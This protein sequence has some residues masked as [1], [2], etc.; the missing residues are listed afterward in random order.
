MLHDFTDEGVAHW[1]CPH[2]STGNQA[3]VSHEEMEAIGNVVAL[4]PCACGT[5]T[6]LKAQ[7]TPDE[8]QTENMIDKDGNTTQSHHAAHLHMRAAAQVAARRTD[9]G[10]M[11]ISHDIVQS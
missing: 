11:E 8:L 4:P 1:V 10:E 6:F 3:H 9:R 2:C 5:R 7:F